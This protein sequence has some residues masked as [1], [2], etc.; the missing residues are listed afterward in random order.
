MKIFEGRRRNW[1]G[2][3][4]FYPSDSGITGQSILGADILP[5]APLSGFRLS[6]RYSR[7]DVMHHFRYRNI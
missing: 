3:Y 5:N 2:I 1:F 6:N 7:G 4:S